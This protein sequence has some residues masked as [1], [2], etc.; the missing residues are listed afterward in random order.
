MESNVVWSE[1][2]TL[3][4]P[5]EISRDRSELDYLRR[6]NMEAW[7][8]APKPRLRPAQV[9]KLQPIIIVQ[10]TFVAWKAAFFEHPFAA[11]EESG[12]EV[13][14]TEVLTPEASRRDS[15]VEMEDEK[16]LDVVA[17]SANYSTGDCCYCRR[18]SGVSMGEEDERP[19]QNQDLAE[20]CCCDGSQMVR[21]EAL[22]FE[23]NIDEALPIDESMVGLA[24]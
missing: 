20:T 18:D 2:F 17:Q 19:Y 5:P 6:T 1:R 9:R 13:R 4:L 22:F 16:D 24:L 8:A 21:E 10:P 3:N 7:E 11:V 14:D 15:G 23:D 12:D